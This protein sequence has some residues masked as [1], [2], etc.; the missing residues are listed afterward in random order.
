MSRAKIGTGELAPFKKSSPGSETI[1]N[2]TDGAR[3]EGFY[4]KQVITKA[5]RN[6]TKLEPFKMGP[7]GPGRNV[8]NKDVPDFKTGG[9]K[10]PTHPAF[11]KKPCNY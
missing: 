11:S 10:I 4:E 8:G 3:R 9:T 2:T 5:S 7:E 6:V 1:S